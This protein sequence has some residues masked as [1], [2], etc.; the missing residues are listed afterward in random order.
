ML[1]IF[2]ILK[3]TSTCLTEKLHYSAGNFELEGS[4]DAMWLC[5]S[6][7]QTTNANAS[8]VAVASEGRQTKI[9]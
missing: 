5:G 7:S 4:A 1:Y 2:E 9:T 3:N 8:T 6:A